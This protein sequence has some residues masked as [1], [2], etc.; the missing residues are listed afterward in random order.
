[1]SAATK[2]EAAA[3]TKAAENNLTDMVNSSGKKELL[4]VRERTGLQ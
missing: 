2:K 3:M 4:S 1:L